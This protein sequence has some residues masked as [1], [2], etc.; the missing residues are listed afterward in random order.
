MDRGVVPDDEERETAAHRLRRGTKAVILGVKLVRGPAEKAN[1]ARLVQSA[2]R[3]RIARRR[4]R[5]AHQDKM[6]EWSNALTAR[7]VPEGD[8]RDALMRPQVPVATFSAMGLGGQMFGP[9]P[10]RVRDFEVLLEYMQ[11]NRTLTRLDLSNN[12][13]SLGMIGMVGEFLKCANGCCRLEYLNLSRNRLNRDA[14]VL[15]GKSVRSNTRLDVL[16]LE[17][18][19]LRVQQ[20]R[21]HGGQSAA[22]DLFSHRLTGVDCSFICELLRYATRISRVNLKCVA[23]HDDSCAPTPTRR[24]H[25]HAARAALV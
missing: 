3:C 14:A 17:N 4:C 15:L 1:A 19:R 8:F 24:M 23:G 5:Q 25:T 10:V 13:M 16:V 7:G 11:L 21:P 2:Y 20:L 6:T 12:S 18:T 9:G 22:M